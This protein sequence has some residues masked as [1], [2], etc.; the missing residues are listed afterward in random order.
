MNNILKQFVASATSSKPSEFEKAALKLT[1]NYVFGIFIILLVSSSAIYFLSATSLPTNDNL[2]Q[3]NTPIPPHKEISLYEFKEHLLNIL[4]VVDL[5]IL[6]IATVFAYLLA[7]RTL[8]P[9]E[10]IYR[11]QERFV[12][13]VAHELRTPLA[14][15]KAGSESILLKERSVQEYIDFLKESEEETDCLTRLSNELLFL[16]KHQTSSS[17]TFTKV[18]LSK[19]VKNQ[20]QTF[21]AYAHQHSVS[22]DFTGEDSLF[23]QGREDSLIRLTKNLIKNAIDYNRQGGSVTVKIYRQQSQV[24]LTVSDSGIGINETEINKV[25]D[26]FYKTDTSRSLGGS[27]LG[28]SI[29]KD[30]VS[31]HRGQIK[32]DSVVD[33]GTNVLVTLPSGTSS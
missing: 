3:T 22:I 33:K 12:G 26:R 6:L 32:I 11:Q 13:D 31:A 27:G 18:D 20:V 1:L 9:I 16:L 5:S 14:V 15:L 24:L 19:I 10:T 28:L 21:K 4:L 29:V 8:R 7:R 30:I 17:E 23:V 2:S 25:F